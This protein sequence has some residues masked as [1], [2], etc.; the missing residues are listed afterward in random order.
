MN[1]RELQACADRL[2]KFLIT[3]LASVGRSERRHHGS[4]Y[5]QGLLLDGERKSI[6]RLAQRVPGG[7]VQALQQFVGQSPW[8]WEPVRRL[9]AQR[10]EEELLP[11]AGW[12]VWTGRFTFPSLGRRCGTLPPGW[13][14]RFHALPDQERTGSGVDRSSAGLGSEP[15]ASAGGRR[16]RP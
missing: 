9:L 15:P 14:F 1:A 4:L 16:L 11:A 13:D 2:E 6:E 3:M 12:I 10:L 7:N 5:A 8:S